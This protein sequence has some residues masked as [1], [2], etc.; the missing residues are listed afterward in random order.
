[1]RIN[2]VNLLFKEKFLFSAQTTNN[3]NSKNLALST[4]QSEHRAQ[5][6]VERPQQKRK[7]ST[8]DRI[9]GNEILR[10]TK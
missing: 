6:S 10:D 4:E 2:M 9:I 1:M 8:V 7:Y 5:S 3:I